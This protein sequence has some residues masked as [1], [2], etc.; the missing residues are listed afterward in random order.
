[1]SV[2]DDEEDD[3]ITVVD[4]DDSFG[5]FAEEYET[6]IE[7]AIGELMDNLDAEL[8]GEKETSSQEVADWASAF[9][10][11][12][13]DKCGYKCEYEPGSLAS[14]PPA[15]IT[16]HQISSRS[17]ESGIAQPTGIVEVS[18]IDGSAPREI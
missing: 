7:Q 14:G 4:G 9:T 5:S 18:V 2:S 13:G 1:M 16:S 12:R 15:S 6:H 8:Y 17:T 10:Y 3:F 11:V